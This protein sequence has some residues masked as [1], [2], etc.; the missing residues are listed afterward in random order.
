MLST[1]QKFLEHAFEVLNTYYFQGELPRTVI[2]IQS[3]PKTNGYITLDKLWTVEG[4]RFREI[5]ISAENMKRPPENVLATLLHE[6]VHLYCMENGIEDTSKNG[7]Y[8]NKL[9]KKE[10]ESRDLKAEY[11]TYYGYTK[12]SPTDAFLVTL[13]QY[14]LLL[15]LDKFRATIPK[16]GN[17]TRPKSSTRKYVCMQ[18]GISVRA[19]KE[20]HIACMD[21]KLQMVIS[22]GK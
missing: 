13:K 20:V 22:E 1:T 18:C 8:H 15:P 3:S 10:M 6:M 19:T 11:V 12:T 2:T 14:D 9:F 5:N 17:N 4:E 7:R 21:C 16:L